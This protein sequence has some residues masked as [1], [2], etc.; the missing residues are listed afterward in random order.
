MEAA[1]ST[2]ELPGEKAQKI[3][4]AMRRSVGLRGASGSTFD[5]VAREAGVSR[6]LLHYYFG[7]KERLLAEVAR[8][9]CDIRMAMID[10]AF[11]RARSVDELIEAMVVSLEDILEQD[12]GFIALIFELF[13]TSRH[14][15]ELQVEL[16]EL[17]RRT[18]LRLAE[19]L[20]AKRAEGLIAPTAPVDA[21]AMVL[22]ALADG[23]AL[24][25]LSEPEHD[26]RP[27]LEAGAR[28]VRALLTQ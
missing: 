27:T 8:R 21:V 7:T 5:H 12:P 18:R 28:A 1:A 22:F 10:E 20:E 13:S 19:A 24:R 9:D 26:Y 15:A 2:R 6:G 16:A 14:N 25:I 11:G 3:V 23:L 4:D 17:M